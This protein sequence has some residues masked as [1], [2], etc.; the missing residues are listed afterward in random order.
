[1]TYATAIEAG[2]ARSQVEK[3]LKKIR[4]YLADSDKLDPETKSGLESYLKKFEEE[5]A[6]I[7]SELTDTLK[8]EMARDFP[9]RE[10][11][12][13]TLVSFLS[14]RKLIQPEHWPAVE[15]ALQDA[16]FGGIE[17]EK[18]RLSLIAF[19]KDPVYLMALW[20]EHRRGTRKVLDKTAQRRLEAIGE[21]VREK[22]THPLTP[23][24]L[25]SV[26]LIF[27]NPDMSFLKELLEKP[28]QLTGEEK[29]RFKELYHLA[30]EGDRSEL[31]AVVAKVIDAHSELM[32][33][34]K[35]TI[36]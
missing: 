26:P 33:K 30:M 18:V 19:E 22:A 12:I 36:M 7:D 1:M 23:T 29:E 27:E 35:F 11:N 6:E 10:I 20:L 9:F 34:A 21:R 5:A 3:N 17:L 13:T 31:S 8:K 4:T 15:E 2:G 28:E 14:K 16:G 24:L 25:A 32:T